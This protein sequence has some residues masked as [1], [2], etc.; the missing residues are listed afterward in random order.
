VR[1]VRDFRSASYRFIALK[2]NSVYLRRELMTDRTDVLRVVSC[3]LE[4]LRFLR[5]TAPESS[6]TALEDC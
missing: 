1:A 2:L 3:L 4:D 5:E 6:L